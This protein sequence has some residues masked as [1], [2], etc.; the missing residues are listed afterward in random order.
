MK[1]ILL[2]ILLLIPF[3]VSAEKFNIEFESPQIYTNSSDNYFYKDG[4]LFVDNWGYLSEREVLINYYDNEGNYKK[5]KIIDDTEIFNIVTDDTYIYVLG[6][7]GVSNYILIKLDS[8]LN[9]IKQEYLEGYDGVNDLSLSPQYFELKDN[10]INVLY[11]EWSDDEYRVL[12]VDKALTNPTIKGLD[13]YE[14]FKGVL[15]F[16][17]FER[18]SN[19]YV[20]KVN[21]YENGYLLMTGVNNFIDNSWIQTYYLIR[22]DKNK[23]VLWRKEFADYKGIYDLK[24]YGKDIYIVAYKEM[25]NDA[26]NSDLIKINENGEIEKVILPQK[27][28]DGININDKHIIISAGTY[29][30]CFVE[31]VFDTPSECKSAIRHTVYSIE[32]DIVSKI[33]GKGQVV[34]STSSFSHKGVTFEVV[35]EKGYVLSEVKVTDEFGN[36]IKFTDYK[37][38]MPSANVLI[39]AVFV[40]D[41]PNTGSFISYIAIV[42]GGITFITTYL[43]IQKSKLNKIKW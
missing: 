32:Y 20:I 33:T 43:L 23:N 40:P 3:V 6:S 2:F 30:A 29:G 35:P 18:P 17:S 1:K 9:V 11:R 26:T 10:K 21:N 38:T 14:S 25:N 37:F 39:E 8:D 13:E 34:V 27:A 19:E 36:V 5:S 12:S 28:L 4:Y 22:I 24:T 15:L 31:N 16:E 7:I 42:F 41:N